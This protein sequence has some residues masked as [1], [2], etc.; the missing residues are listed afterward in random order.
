M[1]NMKIK[2]LLKKQKKLISELAGCGN[3]VEGSLA[4][5]DRICGTKT[6]QCRSGGKKHPAM[7]F[8]WKEKGKTKSLY[9]PVSMEE[10]AVTMHKNYKKLKEIMKKLTEVNKMILRG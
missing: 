6:C 5:Y 10:E 4:K 3:F 1:V 8:T 7:F 9:V 2:T